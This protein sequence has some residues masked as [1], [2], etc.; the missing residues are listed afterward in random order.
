MERRP[1]QRDRRQIDRRVFSFVVLR[2]DPTTEAAA[3]THLNF[4]W[5]AVGRILE[6]YQLASHPRDDV[7]V[8][9]PRRD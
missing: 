5:P 2:V 7:F 3:Y 6:R 8:Y 4:G 1:I 9:V